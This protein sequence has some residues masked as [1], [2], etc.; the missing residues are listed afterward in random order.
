[1]LQNK[2][3]EAIRSNI[4]TTPSL[5]ISILFTMTWSKWERRCIIMRLSLICAQASQ[6]GNIAQLQVQQ[7]QT[8][9]HIGGISISSR[10]SSN[11][12]HNSKK[13]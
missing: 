11:D 1:M 6:P 4:A 5:S 2:R 7:Q 8:Y 10:N 12:I 3:N 9:I 13:C